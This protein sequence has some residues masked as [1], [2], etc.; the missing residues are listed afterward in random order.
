MHE[1]ELFLWTEKEDFSGADCGERPSLFQFRP[2]AFFFPP[3][4]FS[5]FLVSFLLPFLLS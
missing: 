5:S 4:T 1:R 3:S 2:S